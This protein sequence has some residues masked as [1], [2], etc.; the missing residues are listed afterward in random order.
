MPEY[1][2]YPGTEP[3]QPR[4][5][6]GQPPSTPPPL[7]AWPPPQRP[8]VQAPY[9]QQPPPGYGYPPPGYGYSYPAPAPRHPNATT[10]MVLG[11]V[12][13]GAGLMCLVPF[14]LAPFAWFMGARAVREIDASGGQQSGRSEAMAGKVLGIIGTVVL[15]LGIVLLILLVVLAFVDPSFY[16]DDGTY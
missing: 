10:A 11:I 5:G 2:Q 12:G 8:P 14:L 9:G 16:E 4:E 1:P 13:L 6:S 7:G 3:E 15:V